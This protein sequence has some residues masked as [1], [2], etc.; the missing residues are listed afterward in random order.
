MYVLMEHFLISQMFIVMIV[1]LYVLL[2]KIAVLTVHH[3]LVHFYML[4]LVLLNAHL[5]IMGKAMF[6][7]NAPIL[8]QV[9]L[10]H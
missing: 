10:S 3:V 8:V 7:Y 9:V 5:D 1:M 2:A 4:T 6:V